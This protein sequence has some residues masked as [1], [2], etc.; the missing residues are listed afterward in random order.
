MARTRIPVRSTPAPQTNY[1]LYKTDLRTDFERQCG[2]CSTPDYIL[3][4]RSVYHIDHFAP[5]SRFPTLKLVYGNL[6][7]A[8]AYCNRS[9]SNKWI[10]TIATVSHD[11]TQGF[12]DP[13]SPDFDLHIDRDQAGRFVSRTAVG[14]YMI[15]NLRLDLLRHQHVWQCLKLTELRERLRS[16]K[17]KVGDVRDRLELLEAIDVLTQAYERFREQI[18]EG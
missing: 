5:H 6:V 14:S 7:Y 4:G 16:I 18:V 8:C 3:G 10:G 2:Y 15:E 9:K 13:C 12:V 17:E 1:R 11:D